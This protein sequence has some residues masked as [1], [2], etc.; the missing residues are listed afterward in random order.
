M[1]RHVIRILSLLLAAAAFL[2]A[3]ACTEDYIPNTE[4]EDNELNRSVVTFCERYRKAIEDR[5]IGLLLSLASPRYY[6]DGGT[7][8][9]DD[10]YDF[11]G[12][13]RVLKDRFAKITAVRY[14]IKYL[15]LT[16]KENQAWVDFTYT[17]SFQFKTDQGERWS[18][19][20]EDNRLVLESV[21]GGWKILKGM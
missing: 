8:T 17:A 4:I 11:A 21:N 15:R 2:P 5:N 7:P 19:K 3:L 13:E 9:G 10:D 20:T 14:E 18:N 6:E 1:R 12:L 16:F